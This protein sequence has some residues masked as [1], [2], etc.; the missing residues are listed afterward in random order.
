MRS[1][2]KFLTAVL[3]LALPAAG[4]AKVLEDVVAKVNGK[5]L[6]LSEFKKNL[7]SVID[8]YRRN[9]P[10]I[11]NDP[12]MIEQIRVKVLDQMIDD[13]LLAQKAED[14]K[15][16]VRERELE[17]GVLEVKERSFRMT[18]MGQRR[19]DKEVEEA[20]QA[21]L[22]SEGLSTPQFHDRIRRQLKI[23]KVV[24]QEVQAK[25][26][27]PGDPDTKEAYER[28]KFI[29]DNDTSV[30]K[31]MDPLLAQA[32]LEFGLRLKQNFSER[33]RV[34]HILFKLPPNASMVVKNK[35]LAK[36]KETK[37]KL[38][39]G[40]DF[41]ETAQKNSD[42]LES[43]PRGGDLGWILRQMMPKQFEEAA[44]ALSV[45]D[46]SEPVETEFGYHL[47]FVQEKK[48]KQKMNYE[49]IKMGVKEFLFNVSYQENLQKYVKN[50][51]AKA[52][53]ERRLPKAN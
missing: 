49:R 11:V 10:Q 40:A 16:K 20:F 38:A 15:I 41:Y 45:G 9:L 19:S 52:T 12:E 7:L 51:R 6:L 13:E 35:A 48:A 29:I 53:V 33:V 32:H 36:A 2:N 1:S 21:E 30:L 50:L 34:S 47:L 22:D 17:K 31:G 4:G 8:N 37:K 23:R 43:A 5:P 27:P 24:E 14:L 42:D 18:E 25:L 44:F 26:K 39:G 28:L 3:A 46:V